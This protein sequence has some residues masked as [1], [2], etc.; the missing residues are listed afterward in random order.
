MPTDVFTP[1]GLHLRTPRLHLC[2]PDP[3][4]LTAL[5]H[6][7][8]GGV[9]DPATMPFVVPW[10]DAP[11][12][13]V[14]LAVVQHHWR[15]LGAWTPR[16]WSL[17]LVVVCE[18]VVVGMQGLSATDLAVT[19]E[20]VTGS[21]LGRAHHGRGI[22]TEMRAAVLHLAFEGLGAREAR[23][24]AF[25]DNPASLGVSRRLG[26]APDGIERRVV[27]GAVAIDQRLRLTRQA[28]AAHR[29]VAV[30]LHGVAQCLPMFG[31][32]P[33]TTRPAPQTLNHHLNH[34]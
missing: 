23:S 30:T 20:V 6:L 26:Y 32:P 17:P 31:L 21:W 5:A 24:A 7:A 15:T 18:G 1:A 25:T 14:A 34:P 27:R 9:H 8:A 10:T 3:E 22:G 12:G 11:P 28:W 33:A 29:T 19:G 16:D 13:Q 4:Q 2:L